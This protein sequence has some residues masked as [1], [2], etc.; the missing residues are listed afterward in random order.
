MKVCPHA[1]GVALSEMIQH[2]QFWDFLSVSGTK[3]GKFIEYVDQQHDQ[4]LD[5]AR[6]ENAR[7][8]PTGLP[9]F[10]TELKN[11][12]IENFSYPDGKKWRELFEKGIFKK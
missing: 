12:S 11:E 5:P 10:S 9:G 6:V 1:G 2:L 8:L 3:E 7:Y 4:F